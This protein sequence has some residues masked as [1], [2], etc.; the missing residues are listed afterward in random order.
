[1]KNLIIIAI[2]V[3][4]F[5]VSVKAQLP[6][7]NPETPAENFSLQG[8]LVMF[9]KANSVEE[10][11][12]LLNQEANNVNNLDLNNDGETD[13]ISVNDIKNGNSHILVLRTFLSETE[14]QDIA[15]IAIEKTGNQEAQIQ[16]EGDQ[17]L[18]A[19][20]TIFEPTENNGSMRASGKG[21]PSAN[22]H[23][24]G[25]FVNVWFWPSIQF[26]YS[27]SYVVYASP[28]RWH[29]YPR[30]YR[31]WNPYRANVFYGRCAP[32]RTFFVSSPNRRIVV[33]RNFYNPRRNYVA[34]RSRNNPRNYNNY[35]QQ[36]SLRGRGAR[37][38][39]RRY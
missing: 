25:G 30:W 24:I 19:D 23:P 27:P 18:F 17:A 10:F 35:R 7:D 13:Y 32:H 1:M 14:S 2:F 34:F 6:M 29:Y 26:L 37:E 39:V 21:G 9:Q 3:S 31:S 8:A 38:N 4:I 11:E 5:N 15:T 20:N 16:I 22:F 28:F 12:N 36:R 33:T